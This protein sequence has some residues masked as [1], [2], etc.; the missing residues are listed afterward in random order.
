[1]ACLQPTTFGRSCHIP[2][3]CPNGVSSMRT[4]LRHT[5]PIQARLGPATLISQ[6]QCPLR[7][8]IGGLQAAHPTSGETGASAARR[9][10][11]RVGCLQPTTFGRPC[12][13]PIARPAR[14]SRMRIALRHTRP[15]QARFGPV[16]LIAQ[17]QCPLRRAIGG[18]QAAHPT[19]GETGASA[20]RRSKRRVG[21]L[22][23]TKFW[24]AMSYTDRLPSRD[25]PHAH[26]ASTYKT[27]SGPVRPGNPHRPNAM[28]ATTRNWWAASSP[29]YVG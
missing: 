2:I 9:S 12:H 13:I 5:R 18:L 4:A 14:V 7:R 21:C 22:Q 26:R 3:A 23:P 20:A 8:A 1:M 15:I 11:R 10:K 6:T 17:T 19:S 24:H 27:N 25:K 16:T 29:P 28:P